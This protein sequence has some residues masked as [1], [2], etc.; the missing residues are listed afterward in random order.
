MTITC[1]F[2]L[3]L[4]MP[5]LPLFVLNL[6]TFYHFFPLWVLPRK[7]C[8]YLMKGIERADS[9]NFNPHKW[10]LVNFDC[11]AMW[12]KDPS[13]LVNAFNVDPLYLKHEQQG[14]IFTLTN[15][16]SLNYCFSRLSPWLPPLA[17]TFRTSFQGFEALVCVKTVRFGESPSPYTKTHFFSSLFWKS[18][19]KGR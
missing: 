1:G 18:S 2:T 12:L 13:W 10:L 19:P 9:F 5:D 8:R 14:Y 11:S 4:L 3:M 16:Q 6:G 7:V 17:N 15:C